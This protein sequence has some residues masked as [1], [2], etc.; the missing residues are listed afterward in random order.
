MH[1]IGKSY[2][3]IYLSIIYQSCSLFC[4]MGKV[5]AASSI[6]LTHLHLVPFML[7]WNENLRHFFWV[8]DYFALQRTY[9]QWFWVEMKSRWVKGRRVFSDLICQVHCLNNFRVRDQAM[10]W[11][12][13]Y[14]SLWGGGDICIHLWTVTFVIL[15]R[16]RS[17]A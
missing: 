17:I 10:D 9:S 12:K 6:I 7:N 4:W 14:S 5:Y 11:I 2:L 13:R 16:D 15:S 3:Y 8:K 1:Y